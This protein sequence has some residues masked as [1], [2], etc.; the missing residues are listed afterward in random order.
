MEKRNRQPILIY[1]PH[2]ENVIE[3]D[4]EIKAK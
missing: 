1:C 4:M 2:C 3:I